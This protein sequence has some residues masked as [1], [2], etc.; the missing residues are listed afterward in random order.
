MRSALIFTI[1][2]FAQNQRDQTVTI[3]AYLPTE[4]PHKVR[5]NLKYRDVSKQSTM[6]RESV[7]KLDEMERLIFA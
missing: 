5:L 2:A 4:A 6:A 1:L 3:S 7:A